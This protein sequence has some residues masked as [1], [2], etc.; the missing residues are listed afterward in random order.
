MRSLLVRSRRQ[1]N[2]KLMI[3]AVI[4]IETKTICPFR[5][6]GLAGRGADITNRLCFVSSIILYRIGDTNDI[7]YHLYY[8]RLCTSHFYSLPPGPTPYTHTHT[9]AIA[10]TTAFQ[11]S[12]PWDLLSVI[13]L[14]LPGTAEELKMSMS[15]TLA[16]LFPTHPRRCVC[17]RGVT[18]SSYK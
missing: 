17:V 1:E 13:A 15:H 9:R 14:H 6:C 3:M 4:G 11:P 16:P 18:V 5:I 10:G 12:R 8:G 7:K 2:V